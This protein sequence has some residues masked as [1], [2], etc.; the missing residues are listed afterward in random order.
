[1]KQEPLVF[2][3]TLDDFDLSKLPGDPKVLRSNPGMLKEAVSNY[4]SDQFKAIGGEA[5]VSIRQNAVTVRWVPESGVSGL[6]EHGID[7]LQ[8]GDYGT[9]VALLQSVQNQETDNP[10]ILFNL[11]MAYSDMGKLN[12]ALA[13]LSK[14]I[15]LEPENPRA[16]TA[17]GVALF[18]SEKLPEAEQA[19]RR[20]VELD[21]GD[22]YAH[23]NLGGLLIGRD[24]A[25]GMLHMEKAAVLLPDDQTAQFNYG[26]ALLQDGKLA[27][28]DQVLIR[29]IGI[30]PLTSIAEQ[31]RTAR[32]QIAH[33]N[34]RSAAGGGPRMDAVM[35]CLAA[36]K[37]FAE[38]PDKLQP[39][40]FEIAM[41]GRGGLDINS[42][43]QNIP[44]KQYPENFQGFIW[45]RTCMWG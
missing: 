43:A 44:S 40:T 14:L 6:V 21:P 1:M 15:T 36:L 9:G 11:G 10:S 16:W 35:Y 26:V 22:G 38:S 32:T 12:E 41:L 19:L 25:A 30:A 18:R 45:S 23:R 27:E 42:S 34:M 33:Q 7:L 5:Q 28:A 24:R 4:Y 20:G 17:L 29:A 8:A 2:T 31:A 37:L 3:F 39:V 13:L